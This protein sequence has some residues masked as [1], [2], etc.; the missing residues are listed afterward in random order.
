M[1]L[2]N[3]IK[4]TI[5]I[6]GTLILILVLVLVLFKINKKSNTNPV[7]TSTSTSTS[8]SIITTSA[9]P[10]TT[11]VTVIQPG[12]TIMTQ[13]SNPNDK[14][15]TTNISLPSSLMSIINHQYDSYI[16]LTTITLSLSSK[17]T[18]IGSYAFNNCGALSN[19]TLP[20]NLITIGDYAFNNCVALSNI[21]L[22]SKLTTIGNYAFNQCGALLNITLPSTLITIGTYA[23]SN[24]INIKSV[25]FLNNIL[26]IPEGM[27]NNCQGL[28]NITYNTSN[29]NNLPPHITEINIYAFA[30]CY[31]IKNIT[32]PI[33]VS[34][35]DDYAFVGC[36]GLNNIVFSNTTPLTIGNNVFQGCI[37]LQYI[38]IP[39]NTIV[40]GNHIFD[41][42]SMLTL[43]DIELAPSSYAEPNLSIGDYAFSNCI[44]L[45]AISSQPYINNMGDYCFNNCT[46]L[47]LMDMTTDN[48]TSTS[49][50]L[51]NNSGLTNIRLPTGLT[52]LNDNTF[53]NCK[54]L[55]TISFSNPDS[56]DDI[57][58]GS[59]VFDSC[60]NTILPAKS[61]NTILSTKSSNTTSTQPLT[62][63]IQTIPDPGLSSK[64]KKNFSGLSNIYN[65]YYMDKYKCP[66]NNDNP[67]GTC[68][69]S[70][71]SNTFYP[72]VFITV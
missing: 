69:P 14:T 41:G 12:V 1:I 54:Y 40:L 23:F 38:T 55:S 62:L 67:T 37:L 16:N 57:S 56:L 49:K 8:T 52:N 9:V 2:T 6:I 27:F 61:S 19:I 66:F 5:I 64:F 29:I 32:I 65:I 35:I 15:D 7:T 58:F 71:N 17:L 28:T 26:N 3:K 25:I 46:N 51:F 13:S 43:V 34:K 59:N 53:S 36:S 63:Y 33:Y 31:S 45:V 68:T 21:I 30:Y 20:S 72:Y 47:Q 42:C 60:C 50:G 39:Y 22:P 11:S 24:C 48:I 70:G 4:I 44:S 18:S 10:V